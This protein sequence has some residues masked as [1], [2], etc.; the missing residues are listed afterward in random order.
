MRET[1]FS[2]NENV[3]KAVS[4]SAVAGQQSIQSMLGQTKP[5]DSIT[6]LHLTGAG[7]FSLASWWVSTA[8]IIYFNFQPVVR[9]SFF[10]TSL[11]LAIISG[12]L[13]FRYRNDESILGAYI[14]FT[15][16]LLVWGFVEVSFYTGYIVGPLVRP[17]FTIGP[18]WQAMHQAIHRSI[19]HEM[20]IMTLG[21]AM[22]S[23]FLR[24][25]NRFALYT[26]FIL[27]FAHQSCKLNIFFGVSNTGSEFIPDTV[28][29]MAQF[30]TVTNMNWFF[31]FSITLNTLV[32]Y[33]LLH[34]ARDKKEASWR[35][36]GYILVGMMALLALVE[37]W[38]LVL[39]LNKS[40]W[41]ITIPYI[42]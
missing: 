33:R 5:S 42:H 31:P 41:D 18:S 17:I 39:P 26:F 29:D 35:R 19:Y 12:Y 10:L 36:I 40:L 25:K 1:R 23:V 2:E 20:M 37:H 38:L 30:M 32:A 24:S 22:A 7:L 16:A 13:I 21:I 6:W 27:W 15:G 4:A 28:S 9:L 3:V 11:A 8:I 14:T 34:R